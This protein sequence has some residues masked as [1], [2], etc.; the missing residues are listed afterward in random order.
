MVGAKS[1][2]RFIPAYAGNTLI[3]STCRRSS[4]VHP[5]LRGEHGGAPDAIIGQLRFIPAY[6]GNTAA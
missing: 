2:T 5:R 4:S 6:A 1:L 3:S